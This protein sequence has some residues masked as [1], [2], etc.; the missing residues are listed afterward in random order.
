M[1]VVI[2][3][4]QLTYADQLPDSLD[5][6]DSSGSW[7][8]S[9]S[10]ALECI[11]PAVWRVLGGWSIST[12]KPVLDLLTTLSIRWDDIPCQS[13]SRWRDAIRLEGELPC[14]LYGCLCS[15]GTAHT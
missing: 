10:E 6:M 2:S 1:P 14:G 3:L 9:T 4:A 15:D 12:G 13:A 7:R 11:S 5:V 8:I